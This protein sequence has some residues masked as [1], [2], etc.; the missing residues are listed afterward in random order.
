LKKRA[1]LV[2]SKSHTAKSSISSGSQGA[3]RVSNA[4]IYSTI[5]MPHLQVNAFQSH[6]ISRDATETECVVCR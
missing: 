6:R 5:G 1:K 3:S 2:A 4:A